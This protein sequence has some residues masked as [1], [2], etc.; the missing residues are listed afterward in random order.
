MGEQELA[1]PAARVVARAAA[2]QRGAAGESQREKLRRARGAIKS[3]AGAAGPRE[4]GRR[5]RRGRRREETEEPV[6]DPGPRD[7]VHNVV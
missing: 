1:T 3:G 5:G 4:N 7:W 6:S 2:V